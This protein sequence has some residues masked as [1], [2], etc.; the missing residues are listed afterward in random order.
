MMGLQSKPQNTLILH[1]WGQGDREHKVDL[2]QHIVIRF[3]VV[4]CHW[5][6]Q[7]KKNSPDINNECLPENSSK[8]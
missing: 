3:S 5:E 4:L 1:L 7:S 2:K 8:L 6:W